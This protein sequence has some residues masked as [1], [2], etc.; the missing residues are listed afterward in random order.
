VTSPAFFAPIDQRQPVPQEAIERAIREAEAAIAGAQGNPAALAVRDPGR[1]ADI[2]RAE[3]EGVKKEI[4]ELTGQLTPGTTDARESAIEA[5]LDG[6]TERL[7]R[8]QTQLDQIVSGRPVTTSTG[9]APAFPE[10]IP[11]QAMNLSLWVILTIAVTILGVAWARAFGRRP[12]RATA[13]DVSPRLDRIEQAIEA[14]AI[15]VERI[16]E[17]QRFTNKVMGDLRALPQ[18]N[19]AELW[20]AGQAREAVAVPRNPGA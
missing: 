20:P 13:P 17:G 19:A 6:A 18:P 7:E 10:E 3:I 15:E 8:L 9:G 12:P 5:Q 2:L 16:S 1:A 11:R 4:R 14:V